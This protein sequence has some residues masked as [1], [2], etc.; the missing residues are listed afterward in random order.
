MAS[1]ES[2]QRKLQT[3]FKIDYPG[4]DLANEHM[5]KIIKWAVL[6]FKKRYPLLFTRE[7]NGGRRPKYEWD[8]LLAFDIYCVYSNKR[9]FRKR[10]EWLT[11]DD[12]S[13][14]YILNNKRPSKTTMND[15]R[16]EN[17]LLFIEFFQHTI[18]LGIDLGLIGGDVVTL[19]STKIKAYANNFKTLSV[20]QLSYLLDFVQDFRLNKS[21]NSRWFKLRK[22]F[23]SD[24]LPENLVDLVEEIYKN[25]NRHGINLLKTALSSCEKCDW[26]LKLLNDLMD[27]YDGNNRVNLTDPESR[28]MKMKD[29]TSRYAYT[30]QTVRD[31]KTGFTVSQRVTLEKNDKNALIFALDD[32]IIALG[33]SP[34]FILADNGYL[35]KASLE[36]A[37][38]RNV[39]P[40]IPNVTQSMARN[41]TKKNNQYHKS[42]MKYDLIGDFYRCPYYDKLANIGTRLTSKGLK[43]FYKAGKCPECPFH[44][45]CTSKKFK[46]FQEIAHPLFLETKKNFQAAEEL[47]LYQYRG[48]LSEGGFG[49]LMHGREYSNLRR[50]GK[51]KAD[52]DLKIEATVDNLVKIRDHLNATL[53]TLN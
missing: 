47:F 38:M 17:P 19:D 25:L 45:D 37:Y 32:V 43:P 13:C 11:N 52:V 29:Q 5:S 23:F 41:G 51:Q 14:N 48:I 10:E 12:G 21:K 9:T 27:N 42:N 53:I 26:V 15:F 44:E 50:R 24:K 22:F 30:V 18:D 33:K 2:V 39:V 16:L 20:K 1:V 3:T 34:R 31:I 8:E 4:E 28:R 36:Y 35:D 49:T 46:E 7:Y 40:I 6:D